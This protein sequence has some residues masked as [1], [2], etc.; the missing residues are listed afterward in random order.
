MACHLLTIH[1]IAYQLTLMRNIRESIMEGGCV[2]A[3]AC[4]RR[5]VRAHVTCEHARLCSAVIAP[6]R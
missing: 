2:H 6:S 4:L 5:C 3:C 1:N